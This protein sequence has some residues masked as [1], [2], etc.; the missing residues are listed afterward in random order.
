MILRAYEEADAPVLA[1]LYRE[2]VD[3]KER[4]EFKGVVFER[5]RMSKQL[6]TRESEEE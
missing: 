2:A 5:F 1:G 3:A 4:A 6:T